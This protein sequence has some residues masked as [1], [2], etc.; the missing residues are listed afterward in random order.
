MI[1]TGLYIIQQIPSGGQILGTGLPSE[2]TTPRLP[3]GFDINSSITILRAQMKLLP[4]SMAVLSQSRVPYG[5]CQS[6]K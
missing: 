6:K 2:D 3:S 1:T 5:T 4:L